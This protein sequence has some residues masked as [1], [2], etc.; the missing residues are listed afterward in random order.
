[1]LDGTQ[2]DRVNA[3]FVH[4]PTEPNLFDGAGMAVD[5]DDIVRKGEF[6]SKL[7]P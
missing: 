2:I 5:T 6:L 4:V 7:N 3:A 1:M